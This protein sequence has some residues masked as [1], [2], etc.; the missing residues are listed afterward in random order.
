MKLHRP[1]I[2]RGLSFAWGRAWLFRSKMI[3][4]VVKREAHTFLQS[5]QENLL[6]VM[7]SGRSGTQLISDLLDTSDS[8]VVFH[9]PNFREDV[10]TMDSLRRDPQR[11]MR[12]WQE[13]RSV[14][15][16]RRWMAAPNATM[17][18]EVN[19]TI[20]YQ[21]PAIRQLYPNAKMLL[22]AR[23]GRGVV[24]SVMGWPQFYNPGSKGAYAMAPLA[25]DPFYLEWPRMTRFEKMCWAW[26]DTNEFLM[27][28]IPPSHWLALEQVTSDFDYFTERFSQNV[29]MD[30]PREVWQAKVSRKSRNATEEYG[31]PAWEE[32]SVGQKES[33]VRICGDTMT[34]LGYEI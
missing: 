23:D 8:A 21:A 26:R 18:G 20:R 11:A 2:R 10:A 14:E 13:F 5:H 32:W 16:Y 12:Y 4:A 28:F 6:F 30:I 17:Y 24:R 34:K 22:L 15:V 33:F 3:P 19:G 29:G 25:D 7:G 27:R 31:F 1:R 9:E